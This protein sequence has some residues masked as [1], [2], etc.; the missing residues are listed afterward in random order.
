VIGPPPS[1]DPS[2]GPGPLPD[3]LGFFASRGPVDPT[4]SARGCRRPAVWALRWNNPK[5]HTPQR[6]KTWTACDDHRGDLESFLRSRGFL[7]DT[8]AMDALADEAEGAPQPMGDDE[9]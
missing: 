1:S 8:V 5:L 7:R 3:P 9:R 6:R 4:C 2:P